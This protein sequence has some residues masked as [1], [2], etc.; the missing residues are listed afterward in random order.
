MSLASLP[1]LMSAILMS[2]LPRP[3][4]N[5]STISFKNLNET[6]TNEMVISYSLAWKVF[7][8]TCVYVWFA[9]LASWRVMTSPLYSLPLRAVTVART[10]DVILSEV[11]ITDTA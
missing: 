9:K 8:L 5:W 6:I 11:R 10:V 1:N 7:E 2:E 4:V 3:I